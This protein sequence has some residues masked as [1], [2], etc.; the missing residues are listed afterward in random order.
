MKV[1]I[2]KDKDGRSIGWTM[3][4]ISEK[5]KKAINAIRDLQFFGFDETGIR[6]DGRTGGTDKSA[7]KLHWIQEQHQR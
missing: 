4:A 2:T 7:G 3:E 6:Y 1:E 5:D